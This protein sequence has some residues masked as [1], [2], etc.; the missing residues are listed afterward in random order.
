MEC[1]FFNDRKLRWKPQISEASYTKSNRQNQLI[2]QDMSPCQ[3]KRL[4]WVDSIE[5]VILSLVWET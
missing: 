3:V 5:N 2:I 4:N 1:A